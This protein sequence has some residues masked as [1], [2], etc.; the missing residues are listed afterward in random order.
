MTDNLSNILKSISFQYV[1]IIGMMIGEFLFVVLISN[2]L[3]SELF[4]VISFSY[5]FCF[6]IFQF[7]DI[8]VTDV[9]I[10]FFLKFSS[11]NAEKKIKA[12]V[13]L[14]LMAEIFK[15]IISFLICNLV[16]WLLVGFF[17][18]YEDIGVI[19][20]FSSFVL[21]F[22]NLT[23]STGRG[24]LRVLNKFNT[25]ALIS[26]LAVWVKLG[27]CCLLIFFFSYNLSVLDVLY[28]TIFSYLMLSIAFF[29][30][31]YIALNQELG[32][33]F[34]F[35]G[36]NPYK[37]FRVLKEEM[38]EVCVFSK[39]MYL[40]S[41]SMVPTKELDV[42]ILGWVASMEVVGV[43]KVAKNFLAALWSFL[44][45]VNL[46]CYPKISKLIHYG[47]GSE[48]KEFILALT[49]YMFIAGIMLFI[50]GFVG[51][52][53]ALS[54][55]FDNIGEE[56]ASLFQIMSIGILFWAPFVW[57]NPF[58]LAS[59]RA[60]VIAK[61]A[62]LAATVMIF[63]YPIFIVLFGSYGGAIINAIS[64]P[65]TIFLIYKPLQDKIKMALI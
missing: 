35:T 43:Y 28:V 13:H 41:L 39:H 44:D 8:R 31:S 10:Q 18:E 50:L 26:M 52:P 7:S 56:A 54:I 5:A 49:K 48:L 20:F 4:G 11:K 59:G 57:L 27:A 21:L 53:Y 2:H 62:M 22:N 64:S 6:I 29:Y 34:E 3:G 1:S 40:S 51:V 12:L 30:S 46:V 16:G 17:S 9:F 45:A 55:F 24:V 58:I 36:L 63:L 32:F 19:V 38:T 14:V 15:G 61:G 60:D 25:A 65:L 33:G 23:T 37:I 42:N 47:L